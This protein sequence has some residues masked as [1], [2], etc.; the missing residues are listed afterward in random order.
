MEPLKEYIKR[1]RVLVANFGYLSLLQIC[2]LAIPLITYPYL[3]RVLGE[4]TYGTIVYAQAVVAYLAIFVNWGFNISATKSISIHR[5]NP[6]KVDQ[7]FSSVYVAKTCFLFLVFGVLWLLFLIPSIG[8]YK[9][10][11][12][13]SMWMCIYEWLFPVWFFQGMERM[14]Y[15]AIFSF[16]GRLIFISLIFVVVKNTD[17]YLWVPIING[18]GAI[19]TSLV[20]IYVVVSRF[21][22]S[23][24]WPSFVA[25]RFYTKESTKLLMTSITGI[26]KDRTNTVIIYLSL[27]K[28]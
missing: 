23:F 6:A 2:N 7:I 11:Y 8:A 25:L 15:I 26:V 21:S 20:A 13:F 22:V 4:E 5:D 24:R 14:K 17:D 19:L 10:L 1:Y 3:V 18:I 28:I 16:I 27:I 12:L 9:L